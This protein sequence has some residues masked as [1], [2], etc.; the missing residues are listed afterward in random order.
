MK[1]TDELN[2][3]RKKVDNR[4][5][6]K[7][8]G[9]VLSQR[10]EDGVLAKIFEVLDI[11]LGWCVDVGAYGKNLSNTYV[12]MDKGWSGVMIESNEIRHLTL[13]RYHRRA[14]R[15]AYCINAFVLPSG[16]KS[17]DNL[18]EGTPLPKDFEFLSID[19][20]GNDYYIWQSLKNYFPTIVVI[21]FNSIIKYDDYLQPVDGFGGASLTMMVKLGKEK[22]YEF[23]CATPFNAFFVKVDLFHKFGIENNSPEELWSPDSRDKEYGRSPA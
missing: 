2:T 1:T 8:K 19:I 6:I 5:L 23:I 9:N 17:L 10:G 20:D 15:N 11:K 14:K 12:L 13:E 18:L 21:E 22:G 16:E 7:H 3:T 4:W